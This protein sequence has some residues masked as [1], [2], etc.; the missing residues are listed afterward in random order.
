MASL[1]VDMA[2]LFSG[3]LNMA[4][5]KAFL[6]N[7][8]SLN[9]ASLCLASLKAFLYN[10]VSLNVASHSYIQ[11]SLYMASKVWRPYKQA[12]L[13]THVSNRKAS[14]LVYKPIDLGEVEPKGGCGGG[15]GGGSTTR[16]PKGAKRYD[17]N[18]DGD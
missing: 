18:S 9:L 11:V 5:L 3:V 8:A 1:L 4:F 14:L 13:Y 15:G 17:P 2:S 10:M 16:D 6:Y 12:S 7:L